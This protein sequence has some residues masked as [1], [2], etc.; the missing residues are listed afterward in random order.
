[1]IRRFDFDRAADCAIADLSCAVV[2]IV[3][4]FVVMLTV[5]LAMLS[6]LP[7]DWVENRTSAWVQV[8]AMGFGL[9]SIGVYICVR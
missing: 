5:G 6:A 2:R 9:L 7:P 4:K 8:C 1:M 3:D